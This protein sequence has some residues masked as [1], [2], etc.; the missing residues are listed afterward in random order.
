[1]LRRLGIVWHRPESSAPTKSW[2]SNADS[3]NKPLLIWDRSRIYQGY[4]K[5]TPFIQIGK[6]ARKPRRLKVK[7]HANALKQALHYE[8]LLESG[9]VDSQGELA[10]LSGTPRST[11]SNYLRLLGLPESVRM[12]ALS[13]NDDDE[14]VL[15]LTEGRLRRLLYISDSA[16]QSGAFEAVLSGS[17][18]RSQS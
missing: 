7:K 12:E 6:R 4:R 18:A 13:I 3:L 10:R 2:S 1:M 15:M 16:A 17:P 5:N 8:D 14:R 11:I 9:L